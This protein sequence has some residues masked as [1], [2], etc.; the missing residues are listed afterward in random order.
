MPGHVPEEPIVTS[1]VLTVPVMRV[2]SATVADMR[3]RPEKKS[4][5]V[6]P[7]DSHDCDSANASHVQPHARPLRKVNKNQVIYQ[8][9][10][11]K[12]AKVSR[13]DPK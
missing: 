3:R 4:S 12:R 9:T 6:L 2:D 10:L 11:M 8:K 1:I 7:R 13:K 5:S